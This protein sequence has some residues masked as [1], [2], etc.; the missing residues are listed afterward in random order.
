MTKY[1]IQI[2]QILVVVLG[3]S[4]PQ[5]V[6]ANL[7]M[8]DIAPSV[9]QTFSL[10]ANISLTAE[11]AVVLNQITGE[12]LYS[13]RG[14]DLR[15]PASLTKLVTALVALDTVPNWNAKCTLNFTD[16]VG[17]VSLLYQQGYTYTLRDLLNASLVPSS[18]DATHALARCSGVS[19]DQFLLRMNEKVKQFGAW[20]TNFVEPTG[21]SSKNRS[22]AEDFAKIANAAFSTSQLREILQKPTV[23]VCGVSLTKKCQTL[24]STNQLLADNELTMVAGKTG[25]L[26]ESGYNFASSVRDRNG[27]YYIIVVL[28]SKSKD[29]R[30]ADSKKLLKFAESRSSTAFPFGVGFG[31]VAGASVLQGN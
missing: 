19:L 12:T 2:F 5:F 17:G 14:N 30:F 20:N 31:Q 11:S 21:L 24:K 8:E 13:E 6:S 18:N 1:K 16:R 10:P 27:N 4:A 23:V 15:I 25:F 26:D 3:L 28:G 22:T 9:V 7:R 29:A